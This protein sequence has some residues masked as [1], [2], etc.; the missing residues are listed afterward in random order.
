[1]GENTIRN[2]IFRASSFSKRKTSLTKNQ[3]TN[4]N[5][6]TAISPEEWAPLLPKLNPQEENHQIEPCLRTDAEAPPAPQQLNMQMSNNYIHIYVNEA[7]G[8]N[9]CK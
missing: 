8:S 5:D 9:V 2:I 6:F 1:M 4:E 7:G 3:S